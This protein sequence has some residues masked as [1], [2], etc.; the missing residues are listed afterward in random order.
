MQIISKLGGYQN[1]LEI[2]KTMG[3]RSKNPYGT[4]VVQAHRNTLSKEVALMLMDYC[5]KHNIPVSI[6]DFKE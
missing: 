1:V 6:E 2:L 4:L 3:W 5:Q